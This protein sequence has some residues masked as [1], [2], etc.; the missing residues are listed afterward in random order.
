MGPLAMHVYHR[1]DGADRIARRRA[2]RLSSIWR[3][4]QTFVLCL[5]GPELTDQPSI[6]TMARDPVRVSVSQRRWYR[7]DG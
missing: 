5:S 7:I 2:T 1:L 4:S 3:N 6:L